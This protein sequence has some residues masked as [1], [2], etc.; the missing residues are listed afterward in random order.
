MRLLVDVQQV[1]GID[2]GVALGGAEARVAEQL[3]DRAQV[4]A[5]H[6]QVGREAVAERVWAAAA[7]ERG[8]KHPL[9]DERP[10]CGR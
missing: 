8:L 6:Q 3:L 7:G 9:R 4:G 10:R 2:V 1:A 5:A